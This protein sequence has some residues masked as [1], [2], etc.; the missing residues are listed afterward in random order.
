[1]V[2]IIDLNNRSIAE[3]IR[4]FPLD[5]NGNGSIDYSEKIYDNFKYFFKGVWI[6]KYPQSLISNIYSISSNQPKNELK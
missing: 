3:N 2:D 5:K 1:M 4:L 6:G